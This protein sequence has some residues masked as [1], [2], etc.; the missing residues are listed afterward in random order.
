MEITEKDVEHVASLANLEFDDKAKKNITIQLKDI[1]TYIEKLNE[2]D[3]ANIEPTSHVLPLK[4]V[5]K[6]DVMKK[7][8]ESEK[9]F[10]QAPQFD[11]DHFEVPKV[12]E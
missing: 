11:K 8:F 9:S 3:T 12:I 6:D 5:F 4:N 7:V 1:L 2:I 10:Q